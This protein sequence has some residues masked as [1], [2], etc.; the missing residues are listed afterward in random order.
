MNPLSK[1]PQSV[2]ENTHHYLLKNDFEFIV[3]GLGGLG[4]GAAYWLARQGK[5]VLG[6]EQ[7]DLGHVRGGSQD[8]SRIIRLSYHTPQYIELA[9]QAYRAWADLEEDAEEK[10]ILKTGGLDFSPPNAKIPLSDYIDSM[11]AAGVPFETLSAAETMRRWPQFRLDD[12]TRALYQA[13]SGIAP[14]AKGNATH[15]RMAQV[16]GA[17]LRDNT[18]ITAIRPLAGEIELTAGGEE[19]RCQ[20]LILTPGAWTN[21][22][23]A[24][25]GLHLPLEV[26]QEQVTY[27]ASPRVED[28]TLDR[29]PVWIWMDEPCFYGFPVYG[30]SGPKVAQDVGGKLTT[31]DTRTFDPNPETLA[32][33]EAFIRKHLPTLIGPHIYTKTCL[34]TLTPDR[35]FVIDTLPGHPN[36]AIA[37][38]AGHAYKFAS[39]IGKTLAELAIHGLTTAD[40]SPFKFDRPILQMENPPRS[41]IV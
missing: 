9:K 25:F 7:F 37:V 29:F 39:V 12:G 28:F 4:N 30:E 34:Y 17:T 36:I 31:A 21:T 41:Y 10:L 33:S 14:A 27:Y 8:H 23:L 1:R 35:D 6:L 15:L 16:H 26:T 20:T 24:H 3:L 5:D 19:L 40:I 22:A 11:T 13:E 18:P 32:R 38:G 2:A